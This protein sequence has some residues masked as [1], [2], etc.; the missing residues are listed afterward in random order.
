[1]SSLA[2]RKALPASHLQFIPTHLVNIDTHRTNSV[3]CNFV[4]KLIFCQSR[5][6]NC[7]YFLA[8]D[9]NQI[10]TRYKITPQNSPKVNYH[11]EQ[12]N[13]DLV[14]RPSKH[15]IFKKIFAAQGL[16]D[17]GSVVSQSCCCS[18]QIDALEQ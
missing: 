7:K 4:L 16:C 11:C 15:H 14:N 17:S 1:M 13:R 18:E 12:V 10:K 9:K 8:K 6:H 2:V 5:K 3:N